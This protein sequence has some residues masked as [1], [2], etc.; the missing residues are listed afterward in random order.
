[1]CV[2]ACLCV[3]V[4]VYAYTCVCERVSVSEC[5]YVYMRSR[6]YLLGFLG[7]ICMGF[8]EDMYMGSSGSL[9]D[10]FVRIR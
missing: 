2:S 3:C 9:E 1:M 7:I 8:F 10:A 4:F 6:A 5:I